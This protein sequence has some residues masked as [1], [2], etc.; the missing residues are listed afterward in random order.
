MRVAWQDIG[1][2][3]VVTDGVHLDPAGPPA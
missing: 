2:W 3:S 1:G